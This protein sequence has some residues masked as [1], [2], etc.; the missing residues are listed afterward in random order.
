MHITGYMYCWFNCFFFCFFFLWL[1]VAA[2]ISD[3]APDIIV[4]GSMAV[5]SKQNQT[6]LF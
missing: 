4:F 5:T 1:D 6:L 2:A 3:T